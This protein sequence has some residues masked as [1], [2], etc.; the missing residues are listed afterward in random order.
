MKVT[1]RY[2]LLF[3]YFDEFKQCEIEARENEIGLWS[4]G[5]GEESRVAHKNENTIV[6]VTRAGKKYHREGCSYFK[7][8]QNIY[9]SRGSMQKKVWAVV[10]V[11]SSRV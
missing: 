2:L 9:I 3:K 10:N 6:Y 7:K 1:G 11:Q 5:E 8:K 4:D